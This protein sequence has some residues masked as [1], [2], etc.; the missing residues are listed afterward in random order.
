[1]L[2]GLTI[3]PLKATAL[4][5]C[6]WRSGRAALGSTVLATCKAMRWRTKRLTAQVTQGQHRLE[7]ASKVL[8][9]LPQG[10]SSQGNRSFSAFVSC[11]MKT[12]MPR[13]G[14]CCLR[15][16]SRSTLMHTIIR[17][18]TADWMFTPCGLKGGPRKHRLT[19][20]RTANMQSRQTWGSASR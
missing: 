15:L 6:A 3:G 17:G 20:W 4:F 2:L 14:H 11:C 10:W 5:T 16:A 19:D 18:C 7:Q 13:S 8:Q 9:Q 1:V 12:P